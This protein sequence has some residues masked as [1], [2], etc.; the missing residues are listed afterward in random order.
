MRFY[1]GQHRFYCGVDLHARTMHVCVLDHDGQVVCD[2][3]LPCRPEA[4]LRALA[5]F[6]D[7]LVVGAEC[8]FA[9]YWLADLCAREGDLTMRLMRPRTETLG[10]GPSGPALSEEPPSHVPGYEIEKELG[11]GGMGV[12]YKARDVQ[13]NRVVALKVLHAG[14]GVAVEWL[15]RLRREAEAVARLQHPNILA[16]GLVRTGP[17]HGNVGRQAERPAGSRRL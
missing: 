5:P 12:V 16:R 10:A 13:L 7:G 4:F 14:P 15:V 3:N 17:A 11:R 8:M 9:W 2:R 1:T 6:R